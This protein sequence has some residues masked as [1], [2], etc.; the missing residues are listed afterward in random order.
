MKIAPSILSADFNHLGQDVTDMVEAGA[1]YLHID[2]MD[3]QFVPNISFGPMIISTLRPHYEL[4]FDVHLMIASPELYIETV[5][6]AGADIISV[7]VE[8]SQ[9]IHRLIQS[10]KDQGVRAGIV[11]NPGTPVSLIEPVLSMVDLVLVMSVN[12]GF[13]G[14]AFIAESLDKI[15]HLALL[16]QQNNYQY[17]IEVD[18]GINDQTA[19]L[20]RSAGADVLVAGSYLFNSDSYAQAIKR[21]RE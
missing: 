13:G 5:A 9:H 7:H 15:K 14:Q 1:D 6:K 20:A 11:I 12:P 4:I 18:G 3:G 10:I 21:L 16:R 2:I 17:E 19:S 8:A